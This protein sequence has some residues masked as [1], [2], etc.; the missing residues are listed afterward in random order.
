MLSRLPIKLTAPIAIAA[1]TLVLGALLSLLWHATSTRAVTDLA[2]QSIDQIHDHVSTHIDTLLSIPVRVCDVNAHLVRSGVLDVDDLA[3]WRE[4]LFEQA[5]AFDMLSAITWGD[6]DGRSAWI[7]RYADGSLFFALKDDPASDTML[8]WRVAPDGSIPA[9][10]TNEFAFD[11][12]TR[13]WFTTPRDAGEAGWSEPFVWVGGADAD[14]P[15]LGLAYG[16]PLTSPDGSF[17]GVIDADFSLN[18]LS[19]FLSTIE[20]G[21]TGFAVLATMDARLLAASNDTP[22][23]AGGERVNAYESPD[24][25][26]VATANA[27]GDAE[28]VLGGHAEIAV[29]G[30]RYLFRASPIGRAVGLDWTLATII[31]ESDFTAGIE[32]GFRRS[33]AI[34]AIAILAALALG[35]G[36][37]LLLVRPIVAAVTYARRIGRGDLDLRVALSGSTELVHLGDELDHMV[38]GLRDRV[39][40]REALSLAMEVQQNLLPAAAPEIEGLDIAGHST[41]CDETGGDYYDFLDIGGLDDSTAAI[42][43]GDVAGHGIAA[44]MLMATA[45]GIL[46]SRAAQPGSLGDLLAHLNDL[47]VADADGHRFMTMLLI[48]VS[49]TRGEFR[50][51]SAG[52]G[53]PIVYD[54]ARHG[55]PNMG[56]GDLPLGLIDDEHFEEHAEDALHPGQIIL[57]AT[58][59][60]W[61]TM[62]EHE[63]MFGMDRVRQ[64]ISRN[65][66]KTAAEISEAIR[67]TVARFR[68]A[69]PQEDDLTFVVIKAL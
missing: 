16:I 51:A 12:Y 36:A 49:A 57:A 32:R 31:P 7:S 47:L 64:V 17:L 69:A 45:R 67:D 63:G 68:G 53:P 59:G 14:E 27:I 1:P 46:R 10:P 65:A 3:S 8:E 30:E 6:A 62:G 20:I 11:L 15:T 4:T 54:P 29:A 66:H 58:D 21:Q 34:S 23:T 33:A 13:P 28:A 9:T 52:H 44:A 50:W 22:I 35:V 55:F 56:G 5:R 43:L 42:A 19:T 38:A 26:V 41:Y 37:A 2:D 60:L 48:T 18:D 25:L 39:R 40:M 24:P 61:E